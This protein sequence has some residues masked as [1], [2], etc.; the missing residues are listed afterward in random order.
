MVF[1]LYIF[2]VKILSYYY[3]GWKLHLLHGES[4]RAKSR[5]PLFVNYIYSRLFKTNRYVLTIPMPMTMT[6]SP[7]ELR[8]AEYVDGK[9]QISSL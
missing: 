8:D 1:I 9:D 6:F 4:L 7:D 2:Q 5:E 3:F